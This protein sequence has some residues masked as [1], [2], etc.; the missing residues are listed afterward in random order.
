MGGFIP[1]VAP[2]VIQILLF[3]RRYTL[4]DAPAEHIYESNVTEQRYEKPPEF[5]FLNHTLLLKPFLHTFMLSLVLCF[6]IP[7]N[8]LKFRFVSDTV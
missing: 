2:E 6:N 4:N 7:D 1:P 3:H 5:F 8:L